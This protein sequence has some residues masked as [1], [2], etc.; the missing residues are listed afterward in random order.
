M[1]INEHIFVTILIGAMVCG[2]FS[3]YAQESDRPAGNE[4]E[5]PAEESVRRM[6]AKRYLGVGQRDVK[7]AIRGD[8]NRHVRFTDSFGSVRRPPSGLR[9]VRFNGKNYRIAA[10]MHTESGLECL[11]PGEQE[12]TM[13]LLRGSSSLQEGEQITI[14]GTT[15]GTADS[16]RG[17]LNVLLLDQIIRGEDGESSIGYELLLRWPR[18][19]DV[20]P[21]SISEPGEHD[22]SFPCRHERNKK[23]T[24]KL[25]IE[26]RDREEF[27]AEIGEKDEEEAA[28]T[29]DEGADEEEKTYRRFDARSVYNHIKN[30][31]VLDVRFQDNIKESRPQVRRSIRLPDGRRMRLGIA[32]DT[33]MGITCL[34]PHSNQEAVDLINQAIPGQEA[35]VWGTTL[36][37]RQQFRPM[38]VDKVEI[39]GTVKPK[40]NPNI[41]DVTLSWGDGEE[42]Y[43]YKLGE[44]DFNFPCQHENNRQERLNVELREVRIIGGE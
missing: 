30:D 4:G 44:Y 31:N 23:A 3:S 6:E 35:E 36:P 8:M 5:E 7:R 10:M 19:H 2:L 32:F 38:I 41:W 16:R 43:F 21:I 12:D 27:L 18:G 22:L 14:E 28:Q 37:A 11:V 15:L 25:I 33:H 39:P 13:A 40:E 34:I 26:E 24:F 42:V 20:E 9:Q 17:L 1:E 29:Q